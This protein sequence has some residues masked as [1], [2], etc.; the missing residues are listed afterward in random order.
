[1]KNL[2]KKALDFYKQ[3]TAEYEFSRDELVLLEGVCKNL[4]MYWLACD[5]L[6]VDGLTFTTKS[7]QT[8]KNPLTEIMKNTWA[9]FLA[10][11]RLLQVCQ[12]AQAAGGRGLKK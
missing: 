11:C 3:T 5:Q 2:H 9:S 12:P 1:M 10:G 7:G 6:D 8:K 4:S